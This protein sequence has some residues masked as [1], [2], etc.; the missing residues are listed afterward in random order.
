MADLEAKLVQAAEAG[1]HKLTIYRSETGAWHAMA[2]GKPA[3]GSSAVRTPDGAACR[4]L[5][6]YLSRTTEEDPFA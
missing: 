6:E 3:Q 4:A 5:D 2:L 1:L